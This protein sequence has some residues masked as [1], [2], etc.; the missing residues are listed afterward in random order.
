MGALH[1]CFLALMMASGVPTVLAALTL[2]YSASLFGGL[3]HYASG[4]AAIYYGSQYSTL[5][6]M[7]KLGFLMG[8]RSMAVWAV[9]GMAWWKAIGWY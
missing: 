8:L 4:Q 9:V 7:M 2:A 1:G 6:E 5:P 3:T